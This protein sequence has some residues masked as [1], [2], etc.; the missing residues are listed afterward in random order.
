MFEFQNQQI[1]PKIPNFAITCNSTNIQDA[2]YIDSRVILS[3][4]LISNQVNMHRISV[5]LKTHSAYLARTGSLAVKGNRMET[6]PKQ[7]Y[8]GNQTTSSAERI[9]R[10]LW[11]N[12]QVVTSI[13]EHVPVKQV[14][15]QVCAVVH[16]QCHLSVSAFIML[17]HPL[18][19]ILFTLHFI[20]IRS[21]IFLYPSLKR[22]VQSIKQVLDFYQSNQSSL[23]VARKY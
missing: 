7:D 11:R 16:C 19:C 3:I 23:V 18:A 17:R 21:V 9:E 13:Q 12:V 4:F 5:I 1:N 20:I 8:Y 6:M 14:Y 22:L 2:S 10:F 15:N